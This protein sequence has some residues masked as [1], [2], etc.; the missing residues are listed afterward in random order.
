MT[1]ATLE[2]TINSPTGGRVH[3]GDVGTVL[4]FVVTDGT[5]EV[6]LSDYDTLTLLMEDPAGTAAEET[7]TFTTDGSDGA[8]YLTTDADT[9]DVAGQWMV[10][11]VLTEAGTSIT[12]HTCIVYIRVYP[13]LVDPA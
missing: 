5:D 9:F 2:L 11:A 1:R 3:I 6:D 4:N 10:Q 8:L 7:L 13:N 12:F